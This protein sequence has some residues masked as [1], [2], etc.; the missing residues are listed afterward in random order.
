MTMPDRE[1]QPVFLRL[2]GRVAYNPASP[3]GLALI[4]LTMAF[5]V[6]T[7]LVVNDQTDWSEGELRD[8]AH[9]AA[10]R[11]DG[12]TRADIDPSR[13]FDTG[14]APMIEDAMKDTDAAQWFTDPVVLRGHGEDQSAY[15][16]TGPG[17]DAAFCMHLTVSPFGGGQAVIGARVTDGAC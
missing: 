6:V 1:P 15:D 10:R 12:S 7:Y 9:Q 4:L 11:L 8:A 3:V 14:Y 5:V 17:T 2:N 16:I 13:A